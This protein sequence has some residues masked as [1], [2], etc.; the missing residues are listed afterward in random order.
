MQKP[1]FK[2]IMGGLLI[3]PLLILTVYTFNS[4]RSAKKSSKVNIE[5]M[6]LSSPQDLPNEIASYLEENDFE[7]ALIRI[8]EELRDPDVKTSKG[9][10]LIV[11]AAAKNNYD[12]AAMLV[13][14]GADVNSRDERTNET[15]IMEAAKNNNQDMIRLFLN[16]GGDINAQS[17]RGVSAL[18]E[19]IDK[20]DKP[21]MEFLTANGARSGASFE[22][23]MLY[24]SQKNSVGVSAMLR[25]GINPKQKDKNGNTPLIIAAAG[26]DLESVTDLL[27]YEAD[28]NA[29][30]NQG[31]TALIFAIRSGNRKIVERLLSVDETD[32]NLSNN[33]GETPLFWAAY[34]GDAVTVNALLTLGADY[35]KKTRNNQTA[36]SIAKSNNRIAAAKEIENFIR[37]KNLPKDKDGK[38]IVDQKN[39]LQN[40]NKDNT[41]EGTALENKLQQSVNKSKQTG[42]AAAQ[43]SKQSDVAAADSRTENTQGGSMQGFDMNNISSMMQQQGVPQ[44]AI[45][46]MQ[47]AQNQAQTAPSDGEQQKSSV[48]S[49]FTPKQTSSKKGKTKINSLQT[50]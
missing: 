2:I 32:I 34:K 47:Q 17:R 3:L 36:L 9:M 12:I 38:V 23:L 31:M 6:K 40:D 44:E 18:K 22:N 37:Y 21:L 16:S 49:K 30:N 5:K 1:D 19:S 8:E 29:R 39:I 25:C 10:P 14:M 4:G 20:K 41:D 42:G 50:H 26:G 7:T 28:P 27:A 13:S 45:K 24:A 11:L 35:T 33:E 15:A 48:R 46:A 43:I